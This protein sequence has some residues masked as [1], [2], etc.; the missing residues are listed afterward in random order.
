MALLEG[1]TRDP[2]FTP[3]TTIPQVRVWTSYHPQAQVSRNAQ[4]ALK[5]S[6]ADAPILTIQNCV[7]SAESAAIAGSS[8][9]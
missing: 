1:A 8:A 6:K 2:R 5:M 4:A 3:A 9:R 7:G